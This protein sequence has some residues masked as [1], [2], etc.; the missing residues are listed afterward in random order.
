MD[1]E[2]RS[3]RYDRAE[4]GFKRFGRWLSRRPGESWAFFIAGMIIAGILF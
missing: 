3:D 4:D 1:Y 2:T